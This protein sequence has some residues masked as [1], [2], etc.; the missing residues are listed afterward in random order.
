[1]QSVF[2]ILFAMLAVFGFYCAIAEIRILLLRL[3]Q[4]KNH[5]TKPP[6]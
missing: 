3:A 2:E 5:R 6:Q 4:K 1:M